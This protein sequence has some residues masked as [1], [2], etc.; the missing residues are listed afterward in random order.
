[1]LK[2]RK[3]NKILMH[4]SATKEGVHFDINNIRDWHLKRGFK[5]VGYHYVILLDGTIQ[6][7]ER[8]IR[9]AHIVLVKITIV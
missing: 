9:L 5:D 7:V 3:I 2:M 6:K 8:M 1:M 4:C